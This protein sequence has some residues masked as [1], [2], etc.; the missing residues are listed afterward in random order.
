M[1]MLKIIECKGYTKDEAF[2]NLAFDPNC[3]LVS[4]ANATHAWKRAG[5]PIPGTLEFKRFITQQLQQ[6][7]GS[8]PGYGIH[9]VID[10]P[11]KDIRTHPYTIVN[12]SVKGTRKWKFVY[13][14]REDIFD[15][16]TETT[17]CFDEYGEDLEETTE[18][19]ISVIETGKIVEMC[20][21]KAE[22]IDKAK[23][24]TSATHKS[25]SILAVKVPDYTP[26]A[27]YCIYT[28]S[29]AAKEGT[30]IACGINARID[31]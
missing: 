19:V 4:G 16:S 7:T 9:I 2:K 22:A 18:R 1:E 24:L 5:S 27:A 11:T 14:I 23:E 3:P 20:K 28:P 21:D 13:W 15:V 17:K 30:F 12:N 6:K 8:Q 29:S 31:D 26:I 10:P 25:Y